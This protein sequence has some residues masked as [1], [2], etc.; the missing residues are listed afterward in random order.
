M[1]PGRRTRPGAPAWL[2][3][4]CLTIVTPAMAVEPQAV[5][6]EELGQLE[7]GLPGDMQAGAFAAQMLYGA[8]ELVEPA[9]PPLSY[10]GRV[11]IDTSE[12]GYGAVAWLLERDLLPDEWSQAQLSRADWR[13]MLTRFEGWYGLEGPGTHDGG[14]EEVGRREVLNDLTESL[15]R[16]SE[17]V[18]PVAVIATDDEGTVA[19]SAVLWNWSAYPRLIVRHAGAGKSIQSGPGDVLDDLGNCALQLEDYVMASVDTAWRLFTGTG[20]AVMYVMQ[21]EPDRNLWPLEVRQEDILDYFFFDAD[22][23]RG[24]VAFAAIFSGQ[25]LGLSEILALVFQVRTNVPVTR[26]PAVLAVPRR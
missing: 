22:S 7:R 4:A 10:G 16:V 17:A 6:I 18:R 9:L 5:C 26:I 8:V 15:A 23:V 14:D 20:D 12:A 1:E 19:F 21:S 2:L 25:E 13:E 24:T 11:P 3:G